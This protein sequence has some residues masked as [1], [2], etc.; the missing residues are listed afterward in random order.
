[1][2]RATLGISLRDQIRK[3][4]ICRTKMLGPHLLGAAYNDDCSGLHITELEKSCISLAKCSQN[5]TI[6]T[7][8]KDECWDLGPRARSPARRKIFLLL[9][10]S[11]S[12]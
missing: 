3:D 6:Y 4:E 5:F 11:V 8:S 9:R 12:P 2:E 10:L 7:T 1:M